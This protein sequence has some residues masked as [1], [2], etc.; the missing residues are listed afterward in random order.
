MVKKRELALFRAV[1]M[2]CRDLGMQRF[3]LA[4]K[5]VQLSPV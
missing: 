1:T 5:V 3:A 4:G 2:V